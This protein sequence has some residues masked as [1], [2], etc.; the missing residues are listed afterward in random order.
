MLL[1]TPL[2]YVIDSINSSK[3]EG[4]IVV[5]AH[6]REFGAPTKGESDLDLAVALDLFIKS[7]KK[8]GFTFRKLADYPADY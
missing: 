7:A 8:A 1:Q 2:A 3:E 6:D 5:L 4:K